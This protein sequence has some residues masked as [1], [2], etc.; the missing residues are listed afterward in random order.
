MSTEI[1][2]AVIYRT[3]QQLG[4]PEDFISLETQIPCIDLLVT[5]VSMDVNRPLQVTDVQA[6]YTVEKAIE[7]LER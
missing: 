5:W 1:M 3:A 6:R 2:S 4:V 7:E